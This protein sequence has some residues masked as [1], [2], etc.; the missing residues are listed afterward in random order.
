MIQYS[1]PGDLQRRVLDQEEFAFQHRRGMDVDGLWSDLP[2]A[3][4]Q[5]VCVHLYYDLI[6]KVPLF[7]LAED[8]FKV[9][10]S[11][12]ISTISV[13]AGFYVRC[14]AFIYTSPAY[15]LLLLLSNANHHPYP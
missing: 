5:D 6:A 3:L 10:L 8:V 11:Q 2:K 7:K 12:R 9:A 4:K 13:Q 1:F 15:Y 14:V